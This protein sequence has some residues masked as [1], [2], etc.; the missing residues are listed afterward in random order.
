VADERC[1]CH[2]RFTEAS[3]SWLTATTAP[4]AVALSAEQTQRIINSQHAT[5]SFRDLQQQQQQQVCLAGLQGPSK[6]RNS[7]AGNNAYKLYVNDRHI[8]IND[9][10]R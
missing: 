10:T 9:L 2:E 7:P 1:V 4:S 3:L 6:S 8:A 5:A